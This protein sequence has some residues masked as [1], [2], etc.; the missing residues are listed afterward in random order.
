MFFRILSFIA[1]FISRFTELRQNNLLKFEQ[2][3][4]TK[5]VMN[6][7]N[8]YNSNNLKKRSTISQYFSNTD[9]IIDCGR[10]TKKVICDQCKQ[11][12]QKVAFVLQSKMQSIERKF[13]QVELICQSCCGRQ[14]ETACTS[15]DCPI[16]FSRTKRERK[17]QQ[18]D[19]LDKAVDLM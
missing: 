12:P 1:I 15:L 2:V 4:L 14:F 18:L 9:C 16:L 11:Q 19:L 13:R 6:D 10:Q 3:L 7:N 5:D 8:N 17:F